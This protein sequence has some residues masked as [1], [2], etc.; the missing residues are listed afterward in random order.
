LQHFLE[1]LS[2]YTKDIQDYYDNFD[3]KIDAD[4]PS[5]G[6]FADIFKGAKIYE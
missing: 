6:T 4:S 3:T 2:T 1:A 5:W